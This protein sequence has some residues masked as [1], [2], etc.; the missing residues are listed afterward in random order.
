MFIDKLVAWQGDRVRLGRGNTVVHIHGEGRVEGGLHTGLQ[1]HCLPLLVHG[2][3][4]WSS[5]A[6]Y[7]AQC[8]PASIKNRSNVDNRRNATVASPDMTRREKRRRP[9]A[10]MVEIMGIQAGV[11]GC[12]LTVHFLCS[13]W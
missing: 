12:P 5:T 2:G 13:H 7:T 1:K 4:A 10:L 8:N 11:K 6:I 9:K 3:R